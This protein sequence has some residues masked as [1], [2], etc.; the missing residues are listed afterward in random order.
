MKNKIL[1]IL[2]LGLLLFT[3][4]NVIAQVND[5]DTKISVCEKNEIISF[6]DLN[7]ETKED[8]ITVSFNE[9]NSYIDEPGKPMLPVCVKTYKFPIGTKIHDV[10]FTYSDIKKETISGKI[11]PAQKPIPLISL[12]TNAQV[13]SI[14]QTVEDE[15]IYSSA[16]IYPDKTHDYNIGVGLDGMQRVVILT[17]RVYPVS[18]SPA[19]NTV[20]YIQDADV[21]VTYEQG[22]SPIQPSSNYDLVI[23]TPRKFLLGVRPLM[24]HKIKNGVETKIVT[25]ESIYREYKGRDKQEDIKLFIKKCNRAMECNICSTDWW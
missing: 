24:N 16:E 1:T 9:A 5:N 22:V 18:Y 2:T 12:E 23:I 14:L 8:Y 25:T 11:K 21:K 20:Y 6:S 15:K 19:Q 13:P 17:V 7:I 3:S 4:I 10:E